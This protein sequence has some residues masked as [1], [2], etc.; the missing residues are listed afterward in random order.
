MEIQV[1]VNSG[2]SAVRSESRANC[3]SPSIDTSP[4]VQE[5][6]NQFITKAR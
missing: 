1:R 2:G 3:T 6:K 5:N 4:V